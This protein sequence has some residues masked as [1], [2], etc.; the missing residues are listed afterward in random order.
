MMMNTFNTITEEYA[1]ELVNQKNAIETLEFNTASPKEISDALRTVFANT[2]SRF[3]HLSSEELAILTS[4][5]IR[6]ERARCA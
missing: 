3:L 4:E 6:A 1:T 5:V 2:G